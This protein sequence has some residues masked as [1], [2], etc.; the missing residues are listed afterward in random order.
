[1][2]LLTGLE[3]RTLAERAHGF[4]IRGVVVA[5]AIIAVIVIVARFVWIYPA[6]YLPRWFSPSL[7]RRDPSPPWQVPFALAFTGVR[8]VVSLAAALAIPLT[9]T[10]GAPFPQR[11]LTLF[12]TLAVILITLVGQ[13]LLLSS[14]M[15]GLGLL[16]G[17]AE[18]CRLEWQAEHD[19]STG[20]RRSASCPTK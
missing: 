11:D 16:R 2:C 18:E 12:I 1:V 9:D 13:G 17:A 20:L 4:S 19:I 8:G 5:T 10:H 7:R 3:A 15:R 14:V 6:A